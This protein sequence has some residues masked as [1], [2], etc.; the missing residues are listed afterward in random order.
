MVKTMIKPK[1]K[2]T[3]VKI[4]EKSKTPISFPAEGCARP[5]TIKRGRISKVEDRLIAQYLKEGMA[6]HDIATELRRPLGQINDYV[7]KF[8]G[9][10]EDLSPEA[11]KLAEFTR[12]LRKSIHWDKL[13]EHYTKDELDYYE[14]IYASLMAQFMEDVTAIDEL[15]IL[16]AIDGHMLINSHKK[17]TSTINKQLLNIEREL[18]YFSMAPAES[19]TDQERAKVLNMESQRQVL[20]GQVT[21]TTKVFTDL[22]KKFDETVAKLKG[23]R[24]QR[25]K[26]AENSNQSWPALIKHMQE[27][28]VRER[29]GRY[30]A[31]VK[32]A[33][34]KK[35]DELQQPYKYI[36]NEIDQPMLLPERVLVGLPG[37]FDNGQEENNES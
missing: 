12:Q 28:R 23:A 18:N 11:P 19:L 35:Q 31:L 8:Y 36:N 27:Q 16:Q 3:K 26:N 7:E 15:Q 13:Q 6:N 24:D 21:H 32:F 2:N 17:R 9:Q 37:E 5:D 22:S 33:T 25:L 34:D 20:M 1:N 10:G 14:K 30:A 4:Q 29:E